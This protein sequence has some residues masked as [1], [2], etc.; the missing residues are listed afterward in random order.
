M[1]LRFFSTTEGAAALMCQGSHDGVAQGTVSPGT[2]RAGCRGVGA[3]RGPG[4]P[5]SWQRHQG[6]RSTP[7]V[8]PMSGCCIATRTRRSPRRFERKKGLAL[9]VKALKQLVDGGGGGQGSKGG[10]GAA[11]RAR[12]LLAGGWDARLAENVQHLQELKQLVSNGESGARARARCGPH[13]PAV[14]CCAQN[15]TV[16]GR[17][18]QGVPCV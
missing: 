3:G 7:D 18:T 8:W 9:A 5:T 2:M 6:N 12:L 10:A 4:T 14:G 16:S 17:W 13:A 1:P 11:G 15:A